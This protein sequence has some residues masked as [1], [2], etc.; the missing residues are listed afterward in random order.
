MSFKLPIPDGSKA[1][2]IIYVAADNQMTDEKPTLIADGTGSTGTLLKVGGT[3][4]PATT[5]QYGW[6]SIGYDADGNELFIPAW[7]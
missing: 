2:N 7:K 6:L 1:K 5:A 3:G 4:R